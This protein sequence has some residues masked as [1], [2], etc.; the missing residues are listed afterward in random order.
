MV[1]EDIAKEDVVDEVIVKDVMNEDIEEEDVVDEDIVKDVGDENIEE[2]NVVDEIVV[3][4]VLSA[5]DMV[6]EDVM[7]D[8][9]ADEDVADEKVEVFLLKVVRDLT[10]DQRVEVI[11][12]CTGVRP[13]REQV[14]ACSRR[15]S[16]RRHCGARG[17]RNRVQTARTRTRPV[18]TPRGAPDSSVCRGA[19]S[20]A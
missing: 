2:E 20:R 12:E 8:D 17:G 1:D 14:S 4:E 3:D 9:V 6:D 11:K 15:V 7:D 16:G 19:G 13:E 18:S 5:E 10:D